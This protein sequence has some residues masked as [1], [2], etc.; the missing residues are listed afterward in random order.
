MAKKTERESEQ[1]SDIKKSLYEETALT[2]FDP[3]KDFAPEENLDGV[4]PQLP[5]VTIVH[6]ISK[7]EMPDG[8]TVSS[9]TGTIL[10]ANRCNALWLKEKEKKS[11]NEPPICMSMDGV[12]PVKSP[13]QKAVNCRDCPY[14]QY[15]TGVDDK[16]QK[17]KGKACKNMKRLHIL[18]PGE[19]MPVRLTLTPTS[20]KNGD[21]YM[22]ELTRKGVNYKI[23]ETE[24]SLDPKTNGVEKFSSVKMTAKGYV[25]GG[26]IV[27]QF[28]FERVDRNG[29]FVAEK[30]PNPNYVPIW[31]PENMAM[32]ARIQAIREQWIEVF[33]QS[34]VD[35]ADYPDIPSNDA[36]FE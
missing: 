34:P 3:M 1:S 35:D 8:S 33:Q 16:G 11:G 29:M 26:Q 6:Q 7:F 18:I 15:G 2:E 32:A 17:T 9:F 23:V 31:T 14:N 12:K 25:W 27:P 20:L 30:R 36:T 22:T 28:V 5:I 21:K 13:S 24:F 19:S 10:H 4:D